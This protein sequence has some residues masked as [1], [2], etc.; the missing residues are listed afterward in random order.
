[1]IMADPL[2]LTASLAKGGSVAAK[3]SRAL[4]QV[5]YTTRYNSTAIADIVEELSA[6]SATLVALRDASQI[7]GDFEPG[8]VQQILSILDLLE[9]VQEDLKGLVG[10][11]RR[12][13]RLKWFSQSQK[14]KTILVSIAT[15][16][17]SLSLIL[18]ILNIAREQVTNR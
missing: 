4:F 18:R 1:M 10:S 11:D 17:T 13:K 12:L 16:N 3:L 14:A 2:S 8:T 7:Y 15:I 5:T 9:T 6:L